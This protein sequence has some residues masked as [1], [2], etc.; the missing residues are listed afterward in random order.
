MIA[1]NIKTFIP[2]VKVVDPATFS[3]PKSCC[4]KCDPKI[5]TK[6]RN[7]PIIP[8]MNAATLSFTP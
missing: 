7:Q 3:N 2:I 8:K 4:S 1:V 6:R 5:E